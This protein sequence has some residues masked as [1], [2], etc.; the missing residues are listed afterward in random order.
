MPENFESN[1]YRDKSAKELK[2]NPKE[3]LLNLC[4]F[5]SL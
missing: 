2:E 3:E 5:G 1:I 4:H